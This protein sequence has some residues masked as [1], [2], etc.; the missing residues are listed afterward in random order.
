MNDEIYEFYVASNRIYVADPCYGLSS[1]YGG[2]FAAKEGQWF[3]CTMDVDDFIGEL[4]IWHEDA[5]DVDLME[6]AKVD[7]NI[8]IGI[9]SGRAGFFDEDGF[10]KFA[11]E[12]PGDCEHVHQHCYG[13]S[14]KPGPGN[15]IYKCFV[16]REGDK[17]IGARLVFFGDELAA[18]SKGPKLVANA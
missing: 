15:G 17:V 2:S 5:D 14:V 12:V 3:A 13:I 10:Q 9:E 8:V 11:G 6:D 18:P 1:I 7:S 4:W 16:K